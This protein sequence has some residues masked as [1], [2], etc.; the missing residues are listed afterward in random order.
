M[1]PRMHVHPYPEKPTFKP[2][3]RR[4]TQSITIPDIPFLHVNVIYLLMYHGLLWLWPKPIHLVSRV[5]LGFLESCER[6][7]NCLDRLS[8]NH[9]YSSN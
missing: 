9:K 8:L 3:L 6:F 2:A 5:G 4:K 1:S 7:K